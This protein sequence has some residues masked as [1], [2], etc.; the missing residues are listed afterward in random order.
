MS[1]NM[2]TLAVVWVV[3]SVLEVVGSLTNAE[4]YLHLR[5]GIHNERFSDM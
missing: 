4:V 2:T 1:H 3:D 5:G